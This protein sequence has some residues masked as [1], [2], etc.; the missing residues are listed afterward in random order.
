MFTKERTDTI[1]NLFDIAKQLTIVG[2]LG[3]F[4]TD[5]ENFKKFFTDRG[6]DPDYFTNGAARKAAKDSQTELQTVNLNNEKTVA[7]I[8][9]VLKQF[10]NLK[11]EIADIRPMLGTTP[12]G[13]G[14]II[15]GVTIGAG[16]PPTTVARARLDGLLNSLGDVEKTANKALDDTRAINASVTRSIERIQQ[17][18][19]PGV[20]ATAE[21]WL[22]VYGS[23][24]NEAG[25]RAEIKRAVER[26]F[27]N[28][29][30]VQR[31]PFYHPALKF[32]SEAVARAKLVEAQ[33]I[34]RYSTGAFV[35]SQPR[36]CKGGA[37]EIG[38]IIRCKT[39]P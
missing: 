6:L 2:L 39:D 10:E 14:G 18:L 26:G 3:W 8:E 5:H 37:E 36:F 31:E 32:D 29:V 16:T 38:N 15:G 25:A 21:K 28:G 33:A 34:S 30:L 35:V 17:S 9:S 13:G 1:K 23:D 22:I 4:V 20:A 27:P 12:G 7:T 24:R 19:Q 11:K